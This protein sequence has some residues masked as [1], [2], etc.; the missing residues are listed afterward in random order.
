M[1]LYFA[2]LTVNPRT[3]GNFAESEKLCLRVLR[4]K[5][6]HFGASSGI[7]MVYAQQGKGEEAKQWIGEAMPRPGPERQKWVQR[8]LQ[9]L[10]TKLEQLTEWGGKDS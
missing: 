9:H 8:M 6:W 10:D 2:L 7:V 1:F 3:Q 5:P 4:S